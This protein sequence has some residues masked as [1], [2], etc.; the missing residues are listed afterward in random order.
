MCFKTPLFEPPRTPCKE[1]YSPSLNPPEKTMA[2]TKKIEKRT[3]RR[4]VAFSPSE[5]EKLIKLVENST[6]D[7]SSYIRF[8]AIGEKANKKVATPLREQLIN[9]ISSLQQINKNLETLM[10]QGAVSD[11]VIIMMR[12]EIIA[13][14]QQIEK[15]LK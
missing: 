3:I 6:M 4:H 9:G 11:H 7:V 5:D 8:S 12:T 2:R 13:A 15:G 10:A 1:E 14:H